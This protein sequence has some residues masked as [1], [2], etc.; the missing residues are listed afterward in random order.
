MR[1]K[2]E[3]ISQEYSAEAGGK[4]LKEGTRGKRTVTA[5]VT[6]FFTLSLVIGVSLITFTVIF[7]FSEVQGTSMMRALNEKGIDE[8][9]VIVNR[10]KTPQRGDIIVVRHYNGHGNFQELHIKRLIA[11]G[12]EWVHFR[13]D[14]CETRYIIEVDGIN[15]DGTKTVPLDTDPINGVGR[16]MRNAHYDALFDYQRTQIVPA[17]FLASDPIRARENYPPFRTHFRSG[18]QDIPFLQENPDRDNRWEFF[19]PKGYMFYM[20]DHRGGDGGDSGWGFRAMS[21]DSAYFGPQPASRVAGVVTEI[22]RQK[23]APQWIWDRFVWA[24][25]FQ[26]ARK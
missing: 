11:L 17:S 7:F 4:N 18:G 8:D 12:G 20:G 26:W 14:D 21:I 15:Y 16:N 5:V 19:I 22:I 24:I 1:K 13:L 25:T 9:S 23:T 6:S 2:K 10:Y 3:F